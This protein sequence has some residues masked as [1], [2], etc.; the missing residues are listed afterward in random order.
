M[1]NF[2]IFMLAVA[3]LL[4]SASIFAQVDENRPSKDSDDKTPK[5][6]IFQQGD[7]TVIEANVRACL[8]PGTSAA[9]MIY[10]K[11]G[12]SFKRIVDQSS[13]PGC[14]A[15]TP[16]DAVCLDREAADRSLFVYRMAGAPEPSTKYDL[17][18]FISDARRGDIARS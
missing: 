14:S 17:A 13:V 1:Y 10:R 5:A 8:L 18:Y 11:E 12:A 3:L 9:V 15:T 4:P 2:R 16:T 7:D 6:V